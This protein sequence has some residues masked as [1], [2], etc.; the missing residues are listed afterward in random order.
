MILPVYALTL[1]AA[2]VAAQDAS[3]QP[4][5]TSTEVFEAEKT[6]LSDPDVT[7]Y[8][9]L[10]FGPPPSGLETRSQH[11]CKVQPEDK[12]WPSQTLWSILDIFVGDLEKPLPLAA[13]CYPGA[14]YNATECTYIVA[15]W[16][17]SDLQ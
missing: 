17:D 8:P 14:N 16:G 6:I 12:A 10:Q 13:P 1:F 4:N 2:A 11:T 9:E 5:A 7:G 15:N 3:T